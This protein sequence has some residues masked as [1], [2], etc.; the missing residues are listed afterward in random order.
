[1]KEFKTYELIKCDICGQAMGQE[2]NG[3]VLKDM[4]L[5]NGSYIK[6]FVRISAFVLDREV[7]CICDN[8]RKEMLERVL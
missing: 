4:T 5:S 2:T 1:M 6:A 7:T 8:C 3:V